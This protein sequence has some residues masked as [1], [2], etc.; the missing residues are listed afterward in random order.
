MDISV[1]I[2]KCQTEQ[3]AL[4]FWRRVYLCTLYFEWKSLLS[5]MFRRDFFL[6]RADKIEKEYGIQELFKIDRLVIEDGARIGLVGRNGACKSTLLQALAK[7]LV[8]GC[9]FFILDEPTNHMDVYTMEGLENMLA[10]FQ[11]T[12]LVVSHDRRLVEKLADVVYE[13]KDGQCRIQL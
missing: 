7:L 1:N 6:L 13:V 4:L 5:E 10:K 11:G 12:L 2:T 9:N 3:T 8:S